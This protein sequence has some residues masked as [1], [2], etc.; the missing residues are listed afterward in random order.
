MRQPP[1]HPVGPF[2]PVPQLDTQARERLIAEIE[3]FPA[4]VAA[5]VSGWS[6]AQLDTLY[7]N[8]TARQI[9]HHLP[10]SHVNAYIR[11][12]WTLT[13]EHPTIKAYHEG[14]WSALADARTGEI[15]GPLA[16]LQGVHRRWVQLMRTMTDA[17]WARTFHHPESGEDV[18]LSKS[19]QL[20]VWHGR[21]HHGQLTWLREYHGW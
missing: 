19:L 16:L 11:F 9:V 10:D 2:E 17:Q 13:E 4:A 6:D 12:K 7:K 1:Q 14:E 21:H 3:A 18:V 5:T 15:A 20:Y 8:W